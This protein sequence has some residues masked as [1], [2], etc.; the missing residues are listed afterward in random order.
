MTI[1]NILNIIINIL[2]FSLNSEQFRQIAT[3]PIGAKT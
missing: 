2:K 3:F 1:V